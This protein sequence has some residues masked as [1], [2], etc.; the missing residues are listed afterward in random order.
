MLPAISQEFLK[1]MMEGQAIERVHV[2]VG[3]GDFQYSFQ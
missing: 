1:R 3:D 2:T